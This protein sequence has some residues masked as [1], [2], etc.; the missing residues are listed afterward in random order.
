VNVV[1]SFVLGFVTAAVTAP[2]VGRRRLLRALTTYSTFAYETVALAE[3][4]AVAVAAANVVGRVVVGLA[5]AVLG[6]VLGHALG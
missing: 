2:G 3:R 1:G 4:R 5:T 6:H